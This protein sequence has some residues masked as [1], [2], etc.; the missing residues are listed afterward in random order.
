MKFAQ[1][2]PSVSLIKSIKY[3]TALEHLAP[4]NVREIQSMIVFEVFQ[5]YTQLK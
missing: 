2:D 3:E 1:R 4:V 5:M